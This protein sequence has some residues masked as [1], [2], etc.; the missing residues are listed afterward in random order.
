MALRKAA[1]VLI[2]LQV[3]YVSGGDLLEGQSSLLLSEFPRLPENVA[4]LLKVARTNNLTI[5]HIRERDCAV[6]SKWLS[7]WDKLHPPIGGTSSGLGILAEAEPWAREL[8]GEMVFIKH[9]FDAFQSGD[10]S[11]A[12]ER[13]LHEQAITTLYMCGVLTK[14]CVMFTANSAFNLGFEV[15]IVSDCCGDRS[16]QHH[17]AALM[18][19]EG[20][21]ISVISLAEASMRFCRYAPEGLSC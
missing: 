12:L 1:L 21:H 10:V 17:D 20:Y 18:L 3:D 19:Y 11:V 9:T 8:D 13:Y 5:I 15:Y 16:R 4:T 6:R 2:D 7:F 14:A